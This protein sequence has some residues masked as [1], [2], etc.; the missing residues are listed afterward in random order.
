MNPINQIQDKVVQEMAG[1]EDWMAKYEFLV[2][3][4]KRKAAI[5]ERFKADENAISGCQSNVWVHA[6]MNGKRMHF[7]AESDSVIT[8]GILVLVLRV[9]NDQTPADIA[10]ADLYFLEETG[11]SD[12]LSPSRAQGLAAIIQRMR[13]AAVEAK[14][15]RVR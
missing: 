13:A 15:S 1:L 2:G 3:L 14:N 11:L 10:A 6:A 4:G 12:E 9:L 8:S 5:P 7:E